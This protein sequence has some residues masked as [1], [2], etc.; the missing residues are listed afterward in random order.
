MSGTKSTS[1]A[2][3]KTTATK[4]TTTKSTT[5]TTRKPRTRKTPEEREIERE[6]RKAL[7]AAERE[8]K[9]HQQAIEKEEQISLSKPTDIPEESYVFEDSYK[10]PT[11]FVIVLTP[12]GKIYLEPV[13]RY[14]DFSVFRT[15]IASFPD[16]NDTNILQYRGI[17]S[18]SQIEDFEVVTAAYDTPKQINPFTKKFPEIKNYTQAIGGNLVF[19][20]VNKPLNKKEAKKV[21]QTI[22][23]RLQ[24]EEEFNVD[25]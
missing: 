20:G 18:T 19:T 4:K 16:I 24:A 17:I 8:A 7:R 15:F 3:K 14:C 25:D 9:K 1:T 11:E 13:P 23:S 22:V 21:F 2:A 6:N 5:T 12:T 10:S